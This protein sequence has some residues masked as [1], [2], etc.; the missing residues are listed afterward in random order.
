MKKIYLLLAVM[1][2]LVGTAYAEE[3]V[4][5]FGSINFVKEGWSLQLF[6]NRN[7]SGGLPEWVVTSKGDYFLLDVQIQVGGWLTSFDDI[8]EVKAKHSEDPE[9]EFAL[10]RHTCN[11]I[12]GYPYKE[13][14]LHVRYIPWMRMGT[15][16]Y[17][18]RYN[19]Y[20]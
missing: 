6:D 2:F 4:T 9:V 8:V 17:T 16:T 1:S 10:I 19:G 5:D 20:I 11:S 18:M 12:F 7:D 13:F 15:W 14:Y 3:A